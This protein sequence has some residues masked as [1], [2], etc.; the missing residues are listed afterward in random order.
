MDPVLDLFYGTTTHPD[1]VKDTIGGDDDDDVK[2]DARGHE[3]TGS[4]ESKDNH[5]PLAQQLQLL[6]GVVLLRN[7]V[8][9]TEQ[10]HL[11]NECRDLGRGPGGFYRPVYASGAKCRLKMMCLGKHWNVQTE[12]YEMTR[13]NHDHASVLPLPPNWRDLAERVV[14]VGKT[15]DPL[16]LGDC[17]G[18]HPDICVVNYYAHSGRNG[19]HTDKDESLEALNQGSPVVSISIGC[20]ADFGYAASFPT[21]ISSH[22]PVVRLSSGDALIFGGPNRR[23]VHALTR[24]Y[25][26]T[27]PS[28]LR[29]RPGRINLT[30]REYRPA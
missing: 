11:I 16:I 30:F 18:F 19:L 4:T 29:L 6:P 28:K 23:L 7:F 21:D 9:L 10:Q 1:D 26:N 12:Q 22:V 14:Q 13:T 27:Q 3:N 8:S 17:E 5:Q 15:I 25:P 2:D 24:V 20:D